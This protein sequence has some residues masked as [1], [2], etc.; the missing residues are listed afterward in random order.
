MTE[1]SGKIPNVLKLS[2]C[3]VIQKHILND[4]LQVI[5]STT[6]IIMLYVQQKQNKTQ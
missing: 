6:N 3:K 1:A 5:C 2:K 4:M